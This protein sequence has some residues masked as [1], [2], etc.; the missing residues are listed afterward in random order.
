MNR[1]KVQIPLLLKA[2]GIEATRRGREW[3]ALC[4]NPSHA[5]RHPSW[6]IRDSPLSSK[7]GSFK[8]WP[9]SFGGGPGDLIAKVRDISLPEALR[10]LE[11]LHKG[12]AD[13]KPVD[14]FRWE[15]M[16]LFR[17]P[18]RLPPETLVDPYESWP[19]VVRGYVEGRGITVDQVERYRL[20]Y[21]LHG[22]CAGRIIIPSCDVDGAIHNYTA[23]TFVG[24]EKRYLAA[25]GREKPN[26]GCVFGEEFWPPL[27]PAPDGTM[28]RPGAVA[29]LEG[30]I[31]GLAVE[32]AVPDLPFA[33]IDGSNPRVEHFAKLATFS[34]VLLLTD[35]DY[36]GEVAAEMLSCGLGRHTRVVRVIFPSG[37]DAQSMGE[38]RLAQILDKESWRWRR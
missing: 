25:D 12:L 34:D 10:W 15:S 32:R 4:P 26:L 29:A 20:A 36:A 30:A 27:Q 18:F 11:D 13:A 8:C 7:H 3:W 35:P 1:S 22:R 33:V 24:A 2:L 31:N 37:T 5:D 17:E 28:R 19:S 16:P 6:R 14:V 21:A 9:C 38:E 23:R